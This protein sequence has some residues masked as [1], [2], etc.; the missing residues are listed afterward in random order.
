MTASTSTAVAPADTAAAAALLDPYHTAGAG[1]RRRTARV[2][3]WAA[4]ADPA[5]G[6]TLET[7]EEQD[8]G[9]EGGKEHA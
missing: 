8:R 5:L 7:W 6:K 9:K 2:T 4:A 3:R 1:G